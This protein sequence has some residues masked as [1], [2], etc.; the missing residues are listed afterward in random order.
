MILFEDIGKAYRNRKGTISWVMRHIDTSFASRDSVGILAPPGQGKTTLI[1]L[2][3][4]NEMPSEGRIYRQ[5]HVSWPYSFRGNISAKLSGRQ[6]LRFLCDIY[7]RNFAE[8][9][10]FVA[11]FSDLGRYLDKA[12]KV[13]SNEMRWRLS[14]SSLFAM[15]FDIILVDDSMEGGD[16]NFRRKC[17]EY[18]QQNRDKQ[19]FF[20]ATS[21]PVMLTRYC[22]VGGVLNDGKLTMY[23]S[24]DRA[25]AEFNKVNLVLV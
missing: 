25:I 12:M 21:N 14:I 22:Q 15:N 16:M 7:G 8:A 20:I 3:A 13:Y 11:E 6:N 4:G 18:I 2:A 23:D 9:Y 17:V 19:A 5:G 10:D 1:N 24:I